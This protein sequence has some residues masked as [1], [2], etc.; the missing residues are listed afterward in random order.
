MPRRRMIDPEIRL[1]FLLLTKL[2]SQVGQ[3]LSL[4]RRIM[5]TLYWHQLHY[6]LKNMKLLFLSR[7]H[8][9]F[10]KYSNQIKKLPFTLK[11][12][13]GIVSF[14]VFQPTT[15][16]IL[17]LFKARLILNILPNSSSRPIK[18]NIRLF[19]MVPN[20][21]IQAALT[22]KQPDKLMLP[23]SHVIIIPQLRCNDNA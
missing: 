10:V 5:F 4:L 2:L 21:D 6:L 12:P 16:F 23:I 17:N 14:I 3:F 22:P 8:N 11:T 15:Q 7:I 9:R 18:K 1:R 13:Q 19:V 20:L